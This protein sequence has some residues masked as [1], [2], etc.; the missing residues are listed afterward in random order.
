MQDVETRLPITSGVRDELRRL[1]VGGQ[2]YGEVL[3]C[4]IELAERHKDELV[5]IATRQQV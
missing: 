5:E 4:L 3:K 2:T 1:K